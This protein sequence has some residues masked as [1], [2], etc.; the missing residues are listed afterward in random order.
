MKNSYSTTIHLFYQVK[1]TVIYMHDKQH[2]ILLTLFDFVNGS[3][4]SKN[5]VYKNVFLLFK[6]TNK[7]KKNCA[8]KNVENKS[9]KF[10]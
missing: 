6:S 2:C 4:L 8:H 7:T 3:L 10:I 9:Q 1:A 5:E